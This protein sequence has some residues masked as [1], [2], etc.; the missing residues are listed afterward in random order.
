MPFILS[1][2]AGEHIE[3]VLGN[4]YERSVKN[5]YSARLDSAALDDGR[6]SDPRESV[7]S[8]GRAARIS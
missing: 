6:A 5:I 8:S 4:I 3:V 7:S 1:N 2:P